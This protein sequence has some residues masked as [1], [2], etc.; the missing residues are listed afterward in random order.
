VTAFANAVLRVVRRIPVGKVATYG[1]VA[2]A[3]G[4]PG[5]AR[6]VGNIMRDCRERDVPCHRVIAADGKLGG[7]GGNLELKR[8]LLR[9]EGLAV[10]RS[11]VRNF[12]EHRAR[13]AMKAQSTHTRR[14]RPTKHKARKLR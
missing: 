14:R 8:G 13:L 11:S 2:E 5:A 7:F 4:R 1:D 3:A 12:T 10:G 6:A 9:A